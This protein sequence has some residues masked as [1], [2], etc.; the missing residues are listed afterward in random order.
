MA[1]T[2]R[3]MVFGLALG[4]VG[5]IIAMIGVAQAWDGSLDSMSLVGLNL[6]VACMFFA[7]GGAFST[8]APVKGS[9]ILVL[10]AANEACVFISMMYGAA[11]IVLNLV[12][13]V[14]GVVIILFAACPHVEK[15]VDANR[16]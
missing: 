15:W 7:A 8:T 4:L 10:A 9:T 3:K 11:D 6:L 14:I 16:I 1:E 12:L 5:G 13:A 2:P